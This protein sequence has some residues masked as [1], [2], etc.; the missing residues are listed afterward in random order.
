MKKYVLSLMI[1]ILYSQKINSQVG[2]TKDGS[3]PSAN[4]ILDVKGD[5]GIHFYVDNITGRVGIGTITPSVMFE[6]V[7]DVIV[8]GNIKQ[9]NNGNSVLI[10]HNAGAN[11]DATNNKNVFIG[12]VAG[13]S[14]TI[15][16]QN[17]G[18][19]AGTLQLN[20]SGSYN[21]AFGSN[22]LR[23]SNGDRNTAVG[24]YALYSNTASYNVAVGELAL[25]SN[26]TGTNNTALGS[27]SLR[28][29]TSSSF[30]TAIGY[31]TLFNN[32]S[33]KNTA[34]GNEALRYNTSGYENIATGYQSSYSNTIGFYNIAIGSRALFNNLDGDGNIAIGNN[35]LYNNRSNSNT[36]VG[37]RSLRA[38]TTGYENAAFGD[39]S[40]YKNQ[41]GIHNTAIGS[42]AFY[43]GTSY[44][45]S[46]AIGY[47]AP[48]TGS[49]QIHLGNSSIT[50]IK[51]QV[52]F[53]TY[54]DG[55][56]KDNITE[57]V[58]GLDFISKLRPVTY[59]FNVDK[60]N[61][62]IGN[63]DKSS[64]KG[65]YD[66]EKITF[67]GFIAQEVE[68]AAQKVNYNFS[69]VKIPKTEKDLYGLS[70]SEFV[71][72]IVKAIQEQQAIIEEQNK[73]IA[74]LILMLKQQQKEIEKL[75]K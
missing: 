56:I 43:N 75:K 34:I 37:T 12:Y 58:H 72:P 25:K 15:G 70:Y 21:T 27:S 57:N 62:I 13:T 74:T 67:S 60:Q 71:V 10:G 26:T 66:I 24:Y 16:Q 73:K 61:N 42:H 65:K 29:N 1:V 20:T 41:G 8:D 17:A 63:E 5:S 55:R 53:S 54:S 45:N 14:N 51:G 69:G 30:N 48:I 18:V 68:Q 64:F 7:G 3:D 44:S 40:L 59:N 9:I 31:R 52:P 47:F 19:G 36:S 23:N 2:I 22:T 4:A 35:S 38:N 49:N 46:T 33:Y 6:V 11:D 32:T 28:N 50:E 39:Y